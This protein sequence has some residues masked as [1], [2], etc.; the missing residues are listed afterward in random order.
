MKSI[1]L[2]AVVLLAAVGTANAGI[3]FETESNNTGATANPI[4]TVVAPGASLLIEGSI[5]PGGL[6]IAG[7]VDWFGFTVGGTSTVVASIFSTNI[8][9][10]GDSELWLVNA[11]NNAVLAFNDD[12]NPAGGQFM[13]S[14][15]S[16]NLA[17]GNYYL[18]ISGDNDSGTN[19]GG[20]TLSGA[21]AAAVAL[22]DGFNGATTQT[23]GH[24]QNFGYR[25]IVGFNTV[26]TPGA[27]ALLG[28]GGLTL[29]RRRR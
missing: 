4:G 19:S 12:G 1:A 9:N 27:A 26:P 10:T 17:P 7:D 15:I 16:F 6:A 8:G 3:I 20:A 5:A 18:V 23:T 14:I 2:S 22:P 13:S 11:V 28:L 25:F 29:A 21:A 24:S